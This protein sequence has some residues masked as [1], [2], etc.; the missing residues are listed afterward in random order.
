MFRGDF[1][2][3]AS[4][5]NGPKFVKSNQQNSDL[6]DSGIGSPP[7]CH[8]PSTILEDQMSI[9]PTN[10]PKAEFASPPQP[11][12]MPAAPSQLNT[13]LLHTK[14]NGSNN[15]PIK[16]RDTMIRELKSKL[17]EK[18]NISDSA[19][20]N[21]E[22]SDSLPRM[23]YQKVLNR[24][25][26]VPRLSRVFET[27]RVLIVPKKKDSGAQENLQDEEKAVMEN[28]DESIEP[29]FI[30]QNC[31]NLTISRSPLVAVPM[32]VEITRQD[33]SLVNSIFSN[34]KKICRT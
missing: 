12:P 9:S 15:P 29:S 6:V 17:K 33:S 26:L 2:Q 8:D 19:M 3:N 25:S 7:D 11:P 1:F 20:M 10:K 22:S 16:K 32:V 5:P 27:R 18:F 31:E 23:D 21:P 24:D 13:I 14:P 4:F 34:L 28:L 30:L